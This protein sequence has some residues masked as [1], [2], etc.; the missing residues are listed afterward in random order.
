MAEKKPTPKT[1]SERAKASRSRRVAK[2]GVTPISMVPSPEAGA[3]L[4][5]LLFGGYASTKAGVV[6]RALIEAAQK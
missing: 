2:S 3:A 6:N 5:R 1:P 4:D